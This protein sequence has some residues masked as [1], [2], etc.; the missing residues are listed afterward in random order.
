M[1]LGGERTR[2]YGGAAD[3]AREAIAGTDPGACYGSRRR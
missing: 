2:T 1:D 3:P